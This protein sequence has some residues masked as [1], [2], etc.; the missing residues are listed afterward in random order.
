[1]SSLPSVDDVGSVF[2]DLLGRD[3]DARAL[4]SP[5]EI[6]AGLT[7]SFVDGD[8]VSHI[9]CI[10][11]VAAA[12]SLGAALTMVPAGRVEENVG[13]GAVD[14]SLAENFYE[15]CNILSSIFH[16]QVYIAEFG[17]LPDSLATVGFALEGPSERLDIEV[18]PKGYPTGVITLLAV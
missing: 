6:T 18:S 17:H 16:P 5:S 12:A 4:G 9:A 1:M 11:D 7:A 8:D 13:E 15:I 10:A 3:V 14:P 2:A